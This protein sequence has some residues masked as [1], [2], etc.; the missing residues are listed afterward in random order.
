MNIDDET[1]ITNYSGDLVT[2]KPMMPSLSPDLDA[3]VY[4]LF[5]GDDVWDTHSSDLYVVHL[6]NTAIRENITQE[7]AVFQAKVTNRS[8]EWSP[9]GS[10]IAYL[11]VGNG[12]S[13]INI[14]EPNAPATT[15]RVV[16]EIN[17]AFGGPDVL[18]WSPDSQVLAVI[19]G[20]NFGTI[21]IVDLDG[22]EQGR[23]DT[24]LFSIRSLSWL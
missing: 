15:K 14:I 19:D 12:R 4:S 24:Q 23:I 9:D 2:N 20:D 1:Q 18:A 10:L 6:A 5:N 3:V 22:V 11:H 17:N 16:T 13:E 7:G 8:P 21:R